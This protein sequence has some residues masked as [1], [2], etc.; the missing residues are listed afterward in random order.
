MLN[1][2]VHSAEDIRQGVTPGLYISR[3]R[4]VSSAGKGTSLSVREAWELIPIPVKS[5]TASQRLVTA[6]MFRRSL[7]GYA[8][9][10]GYGPRHSLHASPQ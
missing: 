8:L 10:R 9:S 6:A 4:P 7:V 5:G 2:C 3:N 1:I